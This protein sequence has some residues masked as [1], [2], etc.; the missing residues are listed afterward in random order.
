MTLALPIHLYLTGQGG[1]GVTFLAELLAHAVTID[2]HEAFFLPSYQ[3]AIRG[4]HT[5]LALTID[6]KARPFCE[7]RAF[8]FV[9]DFHFVPHPLAIVQ[10]PTC[11]V[12]NARDFQA[13]THV[14]QAEFSQ[15]LNLLM[16][17]YLLTHIPLC[18]EYALVTALRQLLGRTNAHL[19]SFNLAMLEKGSQLKGGLRE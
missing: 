2:G 3:M 1:Q 6:E 15:G 5:Q 7:S 12:I 11:V 10:S 14:W 4:G 16:L 18:S 9:L 17:G 19:L 13:H 8:D